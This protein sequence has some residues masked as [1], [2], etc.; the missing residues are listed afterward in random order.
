MK[1][2][3]AFVLFFAFSVGTAQEPDPNLYQSW[4]LREIVIPDANQTITVEDIHPRINPSLTILADLS[5][6]GEGACNT[7]DGQFQIPVPNNL[8][9][10]IFNR[11]ES[12]C[13]FEDHTSFEGN[14]FSFLEDDFGYFYQVEEDRLS[15][16]DVFGTTLNFRNFPL[17]LNDFS[18][19]NI[20]IFP[21]PADSQIEIYSSTNH[22][23]I[24]V[25]I[26]D[27]LGNKISIPLEGFGRMNISS[28]QAGRYFLKIYSNEGVLVKAIIKK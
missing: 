12:D 5:F 24:N 10:T 19:D 6:T 1:Y 4:Y 27:V 3:T 9:P 18:I 28:L 17:S 7:F 8:I 21:N 22:E 13:E 11:T 2:I 16:S 25:E 23:I 20:K 14:Y 15:F 26:F